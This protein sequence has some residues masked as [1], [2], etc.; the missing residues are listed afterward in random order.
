MKNTFCIVKELD[1]AG[2]GI[3]SQKTGL[4]IYC[5]AIITGY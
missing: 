5:Y 3:I 2:G 4:D 1:G